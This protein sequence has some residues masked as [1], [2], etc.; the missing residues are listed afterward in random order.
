[1]DTF[2]GMRGLAGS[3]RM[4]CKP[5]PD[6][7]CCH[8]AEQNC[9][10][11][12]LALGRGGMRLGIKGPQATPLPQSAICET[13][14]RHTQVPRPTETAE[15]DVKCDLRGVPLPVPSRHAP[16]PAHTASNQCVEGDKRQDRGRLGLQNLA[17]PSV[18][19]PSRRRDREGR[20]ALFFPAHA[21]SWRAAQRPRG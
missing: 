15:A 21:R 16:V 7:P 8:S 3:P 20:W 2:K 10:A 18:S 5:T 14:P 1:M 13:R 6:I 17:C 11:G 19:P 4:Q 9:R 12:L